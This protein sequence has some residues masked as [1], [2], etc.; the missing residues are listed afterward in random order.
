MP[1]ASSVM[2]RLRGTVRRCPHG[3]LVA[4]DGGDVPQTWV[5][6]QPCWPDRTPVG[7]AQW[8]GPVVDRRDARELCSWVESGEWE[9]AALPAR[10]RSRPTG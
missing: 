7:T 2:E 9:V 3:V 4:A 6:M 1:E 8:I 10:L 5:L